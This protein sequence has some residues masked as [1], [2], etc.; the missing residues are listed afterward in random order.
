RASIGCLRPIMDGRKR[1][2]AYGRVAAVAATFVAVLPMPGGGA[3]GGGLHN[4][5]WVTPSWRQP[6]SSDYTVT[7]TRP[8]WSAVVMRPGYVFGNGGV[9]PQ[10]QGKIPPR[11][12]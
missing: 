8:Y 3:A 5:E 11:A 1:M 9:I 2:R 7:M 10:N 12:G 6:A 4:G